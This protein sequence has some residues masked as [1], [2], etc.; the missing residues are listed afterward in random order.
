MCMQFFDFKKR[1]NPIFPE[2]THVFIIDYPYSQRKKNPLTLD[3][4][5]YFFSFL[6]NSSVNFVTIYFEL[7]RV[8]TNVRLPINRELDYNK[9]V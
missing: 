3:L 4:I 7:V 2:L 9:H 8:F 1:N 6:V 5:I